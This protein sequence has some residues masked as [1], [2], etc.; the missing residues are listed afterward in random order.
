MFNAKTQHALPAGPGDRAPPR[1]RA[2]DTRA[3]RGR[4]VVHAP[5]CTVTGSNRFRLTKISRIRLY[6]HIRDLAVHTHPCARTS[7]RLGP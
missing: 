6:I 3:G 5:M 2:A 7:P 1:P 4:R